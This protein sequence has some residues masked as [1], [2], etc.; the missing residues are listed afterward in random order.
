MDF[1]DPNLHSSTLFEMGGLGHL[2]VVLIM[3][4][5]LGLMILFRKNLGPLRQSRAFM[6]GTAGFVLGIELLADLFKF[7]YP[8]E[9]AYERV[10]LHLCAMLKL[11]I[12]GMIL[13][14]RYDVVKFVSVWAIASGFISFVNLNLSGGSFENYAFWHYLAGHYY[15]ARLPSQ[16]DAIVHIDRT[17]P[18]VPL[19]LRSSPGGG[20]RGR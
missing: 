19:P 12:A 2:A 16:F 13:I 7:T 11:L 18:L 9:P 10:P 5:L 15:L 1:F 6:A 8:C 3:F 4:G 14:E 17:T 20:M